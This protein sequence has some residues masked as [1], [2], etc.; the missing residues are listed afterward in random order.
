MVV[1]LCFTVKFS[2][3]LYED[4]SGYWNKVLSGSKTLMLL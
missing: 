1:H 4:D 2:F 3:L